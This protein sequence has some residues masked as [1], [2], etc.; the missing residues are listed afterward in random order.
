MY[1]HSMKRNLLV[2]LVVLVFA[3]T[4]AWAQT[5]TTSLRGTVTDKTGAAIVG[6]SVGIVN[7]AQGLSRG[8]T[9][10]GT[11]S[12]EFSALPPGSYTLTVESKGF[13]KFEQKNLQLLVNL[14][15]TANATLEVGAA[16]DII[17]VSA[18]AAALNTSDASIGLAFNE[19]QVKQLPMEG[20]NVPDLLT[21][22]PGV[23]YTG[24]RADVPASDSRSGAVN[25]A[26]SDQ[27]NLTLDGIAVNDEGGHA[28]TSAL[29]IT[30]DSVEEFRVTTSN[31]NADQ[32][33]SSGAQ[34]A[35]VTKSGTNDFHGSAYEYHRNTYT[36]A[37]D[38]FI[39]SAELANCT[40]PNVQDCNL[41]PKLIRNIF[42]G[43]LGGPVKKDR[44]YFF[45]NYEGTRRAEQTSET[46]QVPSASLRDG[47][48]FYQCDTSD[49]NLATDCPGGAAFAAQGVSGKT[50]TP[51]AGFVALGQTQLAKFDPQGLGTNQAALKY[52]NSLPAANVPGFGDGLNYQGLNFAAPISDRQNVYIAKIDYNIT[53]DAK[54]RVSVSGALRNDNNAGAPFFPGEA[55]SQAIVNF[56]KGI[57]VNYSGVLKQSL[58]N[59]FRYGFI[60]ES[61]GIIGNSNQQ[62]V[63]F[64]GLNDQTGAITR[65]NSFQRPTHTFADDLSW[66]H[67]HHSWQFGGQTSFIREPRASLRASFSDAFA[68]A[69][70]FDTTGF[71]GK[72]GSPLNPA[73]NTNSATGSPYPGVDSGFFNS[74]D[75]PLTALMGMVSQVDAQYNFGRDGKALAQGAPLTRHF[76][77]DS[78]ELYA[79]DSWKIKPTFTV[80]LGLRYSLFSPPWET[81][82]LQVSPTINLGQWF[83]NRAFEGANGI[84]SNLDQPVAFNWSGPANGGH[85]GF[86]NWDYKNLGP[87]V[88]FAWAPNRSSGLLGSLFGS[89]KTS[90]R[91]GF[92]IVYD[93]FGQGLVDYFDRTGSFGLATT[94]TN[95]AAFETVSSVPRLT[96]IHTI[97]TVDNNGNQIFLPAPTANFPV[98]FPAG[99]FTA[100]TGLDASIKT[101]YSY[102]IDLSVGREL[103]GGMS[104]EV[105]Y[106]GRLSHRLLTSEDLAMP[107]NF[108]DKKSGVDYFTAVQ[109]LAKLY[110]SGTKDETFSNSL[111]PANV[112]QYWQNVIAPLKP[113]GAYAI[114]GAVYPGTNASLSLTG[115]CVDT[116]DKAPPTSTVNPVLAAF[117][118]FCG[119]KFN[120]TTPLQFLDTNG[121]QDI[122]NATTTC[123]N[124]PG[125]PSCQYYN[126]A[127]GPF[128]FFTPQYAALY[129][130]RSI[131]TANYNAMQVTLRHRMSHGVQFDFNY[132]FSKS[133][134]LSSDAE[135]VGTYGGIGGSL[136]I[137][138]W[139]PFQFRAVSDFDATHQFNANWIADLPFGR[140]RSFG[141]D[142]NKLV[143]AVIGGW[144]L[145][146]LFRMTSGFPVSVFN[147]FNFPTNWDIGGNA[148][149]V[150]AAPKTGA[151]KNSQGTGNVN[152]FAVGADAAASFF[153]EPLPGQAGQRNNLRGDGFFGVDMGLSKRWKMPWK[154]SQSLQLRWE[155]FN[156][157]NSTRFDAQSTNNAIDSFGSSFGNYTRLLTNPRVMQFAL[158]YE[159]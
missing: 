157:T 74:Y 148:V 153:T 120:E 89:G 59:S 42:G 147:G 29:P 52:M 56:S 149:L 113:G 98:P 20:R 91:G 156:V 85:G 97:P 49:P 18:Q 129:G 140:G 47:V 25:G 65:S 141:H 135:R 119:G 60:R 12:Y 146:G 152:L 5:G 8:T 11:G 116:N 124:N 39:K 6:A 112:V 4:G 118:G 48:I 127:T 16:S 53:R 46:N 158:R 101:P 80:T 69:G 136:V 14:P 44:L 128:T 50:Y 103:K 134:D 109:A 145:S 37:N 19:N 100:T 13:R 15:A 82:G 58:V 154:D 90:I 132:T 22:Q 87:R 7:Q 159:F 67:G 133:I 27:S 51:A 54:H 102:T 9:T 114:G 55:P 155:V 62:W 21:L 86:Y 110:R 138:S 43:S 151:F 26:R 105:A 41:P 70:W 111:L 104:L 106:V 126:A 79:Q 3:V 36:S 35:L 1:S 73:N 125:D 115:G 23:A 57:I 84:P 32:G 95:K 78:Y 31:A 130:W 24:N 63:E 143:D 77:I 122:R 76:A 83:Q 64:R 28:F 150:G 107:L 34:V 66:T 137:N 142:T 68:N 10:D 139:S 2:G 92:G 144:Q 108:K 96:D 117:D 99:N 131:G 94:L 30:L 81:K 72:S 33:G 61:V 17:E 71:A 123:F 121:I 93:R 40:L 45:L 38:Y 75:F 88:A